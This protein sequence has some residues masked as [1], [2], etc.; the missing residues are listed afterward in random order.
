M[1]DPTKAA[2]QDELELEPE[3]I[4]DLEL[5]DEDADDVRG[6]PIGTCQY[7]RGL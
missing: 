6:G 5:R 2:E 3:T 7:S 4:A 1:S